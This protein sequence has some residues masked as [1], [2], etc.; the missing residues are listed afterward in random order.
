MTTWYCNFSGAW[1][2][3]SAEA[4]AWWYVKHGMEICL[5][6]TF[7]PLFTPRATP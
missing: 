2:A 6:G 4:A 3:V 1:I 7:V 5:A